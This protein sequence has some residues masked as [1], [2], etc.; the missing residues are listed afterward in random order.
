MVG[1]DMN[2]GLQL[3]TRR[4]TVFNG[5]GSG[6]AENDSLLALAQHAVGRVH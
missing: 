1:G 6:P 4:A 3:A 5:I 2:D